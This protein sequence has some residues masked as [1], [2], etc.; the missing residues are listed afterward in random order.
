MTVAAPARAADPEAGRRKSEPCKG[1]HGA[2]GNASIPGTPSIAGQPVYF[3]HWQLIKYRD[4]RRKDPQM[5]ALA[6]NLSDTDMA[7]LAA[8]YATQRPTPRP[9]AT[10]PPKVAAGRELAQQHHCVSCHRPGLVGHEQIPRL[11]G[12]DLAYLVKLL[13]GFKAQTAGDLD[14]TMTTAAQPLSE[15]DIENLAHYMATLPPAP[16]P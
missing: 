10:D 5:S 6:A 13:R 4:G 15:S 12:Q 16:S 1:C 3:T 11:A 7:D 9:A 8:F 2:D 14:G